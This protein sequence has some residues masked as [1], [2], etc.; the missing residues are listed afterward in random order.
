MAQARSEKGVIE[1]KKKIPRK[2]LIP[3]QK[4][5][6]ESGY[7]KRFQLMKIIFSTLELIAQLTRK[8]PYEKLT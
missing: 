1:K 3:A 7:I 8:K 2:I 4:I 5:L 6:G